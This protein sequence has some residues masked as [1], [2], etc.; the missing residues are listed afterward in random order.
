MNDPK[1]FKL[2]TGNGNYLWISYKWYGIGVES[3]RSRSQGHKVR[4]R[5]EGDRVV[6]VSLQSIECPAS[7]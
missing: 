4:K 1:V 6:A 5:I 3:Q 2:G 7:S